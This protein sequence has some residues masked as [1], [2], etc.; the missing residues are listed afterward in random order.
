MRVPLI[1]EPPHRLPGDSSCSAAVENSDVLPTL[2][3]LS[4]RAPRV[5]MDDR[6]FVAAVRAKAGEIA[7]GRT[8]RRRKL[9]SEDPI[10]LN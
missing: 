10:V 2:L 8:F 4:G 3:K 6:F 1:I 7:R 9:R 5:P